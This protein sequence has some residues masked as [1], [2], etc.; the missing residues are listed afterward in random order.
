MTMSMLGERS[1]VFQYLLD[2]GV[3]GENAPQSVLPQRHHSELD[4]FLFENDRRRP[5]VDRFADR[6]GDFHQLINSFT[7]F[8][9]GVVARVATLAVEK[10]AITNVPLG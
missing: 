2:G 9:T 6:I 10:F 8:V 5:F 4:R 1:G 3:A 7:A